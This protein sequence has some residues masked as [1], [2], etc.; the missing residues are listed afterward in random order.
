MSGQF[1][2]AQNR[3][4]TFSLVAKRANTHTPTHTH[5]TL[6]P[7][8]RISWLLPCSSKVGAELWMGAWCNHAIMT[9][10]FTQHNRH[11]V[12]VGSE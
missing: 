1:I 9:K 5:N 7:V 12:N 2:T 3:R 8:T 4:P 10:E 11:T 6:I